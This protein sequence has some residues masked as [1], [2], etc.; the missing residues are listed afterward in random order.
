MSSNS[1]ERTY[2]RIVELA[3]KGEIVAGDPF[4]I[5]A[6]YV[7]DLCRREEKRRAGR[8]SSPVA[9]KPHRD[10]IEE[11]RRGLMSAADDMLTDFRAVAKRTPAKA[12]PERGRQIARLLREASAIP[13]PKADTPSAPGAKRDG[14]REGGRP[15]AAQ[16][17]A[18]SQRTEITVQT[19]ARITV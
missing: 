13:I 14:H 17:E 18:C 15:E 16:R 7:G 6:E 9:D 2:P 10:A 3:A 1:F 8:Y 4:E 11:L 5:P 19:A 12:D